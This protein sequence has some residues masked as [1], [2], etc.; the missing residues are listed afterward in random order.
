MYYLLSQ[1]NNWYI[2]CQVKIALTYMANSYQNKNTMS[3]T[4]PGCIHYKLVLEVGG[5]IET[6]RESVRVRARS[7]HH[8]A[9]DDTALFFSC[10]CVCFAKD[11]LYHWATSQAL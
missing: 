11:L 3:G 9:I 10:V 1:I 2:G 5:K 6:E 7:G 8:S 4:I